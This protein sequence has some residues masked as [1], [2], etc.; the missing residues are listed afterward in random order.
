MADETT[1][2]QVNEDA[3]PAAPEPIIEEGMDEAP[4]P[5]STTID[6]E[7]ELKREREAREKA[8]AALADRAFKEREAKRHK[9][10][11]EDNE[12][13]EQL[14][15]RKDLTEVLAQERQTT[16]KVLAAGR[17]QDIAKGMASS[18]AEAALLV[19]IHKNRTWPAS[20]P[21]EEQLEEAHA[22][23]NKKR[24]APIL[25]ETQRALRSRELA[26]HTVAAT[27]IDAPQGSEAQLSA[28]DAAGIK[29]SGFAWNGAN[30][31]Y[32]KK[33]PNGDLLIRD[34]QTKQTRH[35]KRGQ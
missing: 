34:P 13:G 31:Q 4:A 1:E 28:A 16:E 27:H 24:L 20:M 23:A 22:I 26:G 14:L 3:E 12:D 21:L 11:G 32:E 35:I 29:A 18:E 5:S 6:Y 33:L 25:S 8:E 9:P 7:A 19:E 17:I 30:R 10:Q 15:T 2:P